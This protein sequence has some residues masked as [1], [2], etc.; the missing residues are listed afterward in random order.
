[1]QE[2]SRRKGSGKIV[3]QAGK[4]VKRFYIRGKHA[5]V[6]SRG[7]FLFVFLARESRSRKGGTDME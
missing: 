7:V 1:V 4:D 6:V 5:D 2:C 3:R